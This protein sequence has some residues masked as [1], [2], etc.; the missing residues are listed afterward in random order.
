MIFM[1]M[2]YIHK[3]NIKQLRN[4][5]P[6]ILE[7]N[8]IDL[9]LCG[10]DHIYSRTYTLKNNK[11]TKEFII[12]RFDDFNEKVEIINNSKGI[13]YITGGSCTGSKFYKSTNNKSNYV[14][15]KY[16]EENPLYTIINVS[17]DKIIIKTYKVNS[18]EMIDSK[19]IIN[20]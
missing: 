3:K 18:D 5:L 6:Q 15:F 14:K 12:E 4:T 10:H 9:A 19:I 13:T 7:K 17:K 16:D 8:K 2:V 11:K 20:K 1:E